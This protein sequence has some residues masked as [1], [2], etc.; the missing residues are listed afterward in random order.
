MDIESVNNFFLQ[1][2]FIFFCYQ[3]TVLEIVCK[4]LTSHTIW[5]FYILTFMYLN[6]AKIQEI[7]YSIMYKNN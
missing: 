6:Q 5:D 1:N 3:D 4:I 2:R 7:N